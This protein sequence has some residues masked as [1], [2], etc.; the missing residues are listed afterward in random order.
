MASKIRN[1][2]QLEQD[3]QRVLIRMGEL[4]SKYSIPRVLK[5]A[6]YRSD[7]TYFEIGRQ[8]MDPAAE[9]TYNTYVRILAELTAEKMEVE[10]EKSY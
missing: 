9:N 5:P 3:I 8:W 7:P 4:L 6:Q 10:N 1:I 2:Q